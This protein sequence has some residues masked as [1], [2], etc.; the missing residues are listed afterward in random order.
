MRRRVSTTT[1]KL[2]QALKLDLRCQ[3]SNFLKVFSPSKV[4][5]EVNGG[6]KEKWILQIKSFGWEEQKVRFTA[7]KLCSLL[8][9]R[10]IESWQGIKKFEASFPPTTFLVIFFL[11]IERISCESSTKGDEKKKIPI[12]LFDFIH[13]ALV[14]KAISSCRVGEVFINGVTA[15]TWVEILSN[16]PSVRNRLWVVKFKVGW[17]MK[18]PSAISLRSIHAHFNWFE[19]LLREKVINVYLQ[20]LHKLWLD[21]C[22]PF[23]GENSFSHQ[24]EMAQNVGNSRAISR[25]AAAVLLASSPRA[26]LVE[27]TSSLLL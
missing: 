22:K 18:A 9:R 15:K 3:S 12:E 16:W 21:A 17:V 27:T 10:K 5:K 24:G 14:L 8:D 13:V 7:K 19:F 4:W 2:R 1:K 25:N 23:S 26:E 11:F 6:G 20:L